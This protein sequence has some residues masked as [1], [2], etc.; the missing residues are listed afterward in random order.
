MGQEIVVRITHVCV[1][2]ALRTG[3]AH[4]SYSKN[5]R[6]YCKH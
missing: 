3:Y 2:K 6:V 5:V 1:C 4:G